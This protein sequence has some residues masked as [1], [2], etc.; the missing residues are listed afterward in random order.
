MFLDCDEATQDHLFR[1]DHTDIACLEA[2]FNISSLRPNTL[3]CRPAEQ[4]MTISRN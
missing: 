1:V 4:A 3:V 2:V